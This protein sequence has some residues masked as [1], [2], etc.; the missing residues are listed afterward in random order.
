M[1]DNSILTASRVAGVKGRGVAHFT[2]CN[3]FRN[4]CVS[5]TLVMLIWKKLFSAHATVTIVRAT[6]FDEKP[7]R[8]SSLQADVT[9][10]T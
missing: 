9:R 4:S 8:E 10:T 5:L 7:V 3:S 2:F 6:T 1:P